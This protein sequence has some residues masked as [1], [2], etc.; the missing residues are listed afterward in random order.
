MRLAM[1]RLMVPLFLA[2]LPTLIACLIFV[3]TLRLRGANAR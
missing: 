2:F 1:A 3:G